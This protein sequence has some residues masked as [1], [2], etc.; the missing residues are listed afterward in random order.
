MSVIKD[1]D[2]FTLLEIL[3]AVFIMSLGF[4]AAAQMQFLSLRQKQ[5]AEQGTI[6]TNV[7]QY[8]SD[9][10]MAE[11]RRRYLLNATAY[12]DAQAGRAPNLNY[13]NGSANSVC[14]VCPCDP[15][16]AITPNGVTETCAA[17]DVNNFNPDNLNF[18][19]AVTQCKADGA[20]ISG[21]GS[22][23]LYAVKQ[24]TTTQAVL[25]GVQT[26]TVAVTYAVKTP[27]QFDKTGITGITSV[28]LSNTLVTQT[29]EVSAN[30][31]DF[32]DFIPGPGWDAV[33]VPHI[34]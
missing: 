3:V 6:A 4:L 19:T 18:R 10:D 16:E 23:P 33:N 9:N 21:A 1:Q 17:I 22:T 5:L 27:S 12:I 7:I 30:E 20:V 31:A 25:N 14:G 13:C 29:Y 2:G 28:S 11:V 32:S 34:P 8:I 15:L 24:A 26:L